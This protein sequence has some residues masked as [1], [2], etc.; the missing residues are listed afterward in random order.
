[1]AILYLGGKCSVCSTTETLQIHHKDGNAENNE[2][3]NFELLC[4]ECHKNNHKMGVKLYGVIKCPSCG[5]S[6]T[7]DGRSYLANQ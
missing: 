4:R 2:L 3:S 6:I 7:I 1:M 5:T